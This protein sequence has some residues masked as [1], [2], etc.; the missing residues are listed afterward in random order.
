LL[1]TACA[2]K[3][4]EPSAFDSKLF[5]NNK[6]NV[7]LGFDLRNDNS[8][9][10]GLV[11]NARGTTSARPILETIAL[12]FESSSVENNQP[13]FSTSGSFN[14]STLINY[15][16][17]PTTYGQFYIGI[18]PEFEPPPKLYTVPDDVQYSVAL[19]RMGLVRI[20]VYKYPE[21]DSNRPDWLLNEGVLANTQIDAIGVV[22]P[23]DAQGAPIRDTTVT[24]IP[25]PLAYKN[26]NARFYPANSVAA[27]NVRAIEI[28]YRVPADQTSELIQEYGLKLFGILLPLGMIF[29]RR[30]SK[31]KG[32]MLLFYIV[33]GIQAAIVIV[34]LGVSIL[35]W[36]DSSLHNVLDLMLAIIGAIIAVYSLRSESIRSKAEVKESY[37]V[38]KARSRKVPKKSR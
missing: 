18:V 28:E 1:L 29:Y 30:L 23:K 10:A 21:V 8:P 3:T 4:E 5:S 32:N 11:I 26:G 7:T 27:G 19:V 9:I 17:F 15:Y 35:S 2:G 25:G 33:V 36:G 31:R 14:Q 22:Y 16:L 38:S 13:L 6:F 20:F 34:L 24:A 12:P 37:I